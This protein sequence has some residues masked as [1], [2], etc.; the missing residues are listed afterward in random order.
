MLSMAPTGNFLGLLALVVLAAIFCVSSLGHVRSP[1]LQSTPLRCSTVRTPIVSGRGAAMA[2]GLVYGNQNPTISKYWRNG[3]SS[4]S[5]RAR[6]GVES[7][8][9][10]VVSGFE[11]KVW[12]PEEGDKLLSMLSEWWLE[13]QQCETF[14]IGTPNPEA[15]NII[16]AFKARVRGAD[17]DAVVSFAPDSKD[18]QVLMS[19]KGWR[20]SA[21]VVSPFTPEESKASAEKFLSVLKEKAEAAGEKLDMPVADALKP[22]GLDSFA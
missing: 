15:K 20:V 6:A 8:E 22:F 7:L 4:S 14:E 9:P 11:L 3:R 13:H 19:V 18:P 16:R 1:S 12:T 17:G 5:L 21:V 2:Y 10:S